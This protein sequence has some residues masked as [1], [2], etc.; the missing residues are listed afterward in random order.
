LTSPPFLPFCRETLRQ[1]ECLDAGECWDYKK[2]DCKSIDSTEGCPGGG[3]PSSLKW[4]VCIGMPFFS[5]M[6]AVLAGVI[7]VSIGM[8]VYRHAAQSVFT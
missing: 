3:D 4:M 6:G 1:D 8:L 7:S 5:F 2:A